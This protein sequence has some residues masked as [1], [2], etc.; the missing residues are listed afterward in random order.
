MIDRITVGGAALMASL[1]LGTGLI[2]W[3]VTPV[4]D[5][6]R[7]RAP[8]MSVVLP[9]TALDELL[10]PWPEPASG[11]PVVWAFRECPESG[12]DE[13]HAMHADGSRTCSCCFQTTTGDPS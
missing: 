9:D 1:A 5:K 11:R 8:R 10:G 2:R 4:R 7:H 3:A 13:P 12:L 6:G